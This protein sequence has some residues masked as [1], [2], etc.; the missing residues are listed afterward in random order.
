MNIHTKLEILNQNSNLA[1]LGVSPWIDWVLSLPWSSPVKEPWH[2]YK[3]KDEK[4]EEGEEWRTVEREKDIEEFDPKACT[5][6]N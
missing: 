3:K 4:S 2:L 6:S 5:A 1:L